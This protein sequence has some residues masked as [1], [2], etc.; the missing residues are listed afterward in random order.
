[1]LFC[2]NFSLTLHLAFSLSSSFLVIFISSSFY[3]VL[4]F[5]WQARSN[6]L[7]GWEKKNLIDMRC[8]VARYSRQ[9]IKTRLFSTVFPSLS[10]YLFASSRN[11]WF[12]THT[13]T[14]TSNRNIF[15]FSSSLA[16]SRNWF[17]MFS[18]HLL[19][20][21]RKK[22]DVNEE[23]NRLWIKMPWMFRK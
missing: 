20:S 19:N 17:F 22:S 5:L 8:K 14:H 12:L 7:I 15:D 3:S 4:Y 6:K 13:H 21:R 11:K 10:L 1:M 16:L 9:D 2:Y 23:T 18:Q